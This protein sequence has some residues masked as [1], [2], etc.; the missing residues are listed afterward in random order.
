M[1]KAYKITSVLCLL[2]AVLAVVVG[3]SALTA[4]RRSFFMGYALFG[5]IRS[6]GVMG[7]IGNVFIIVFTVACYG[8]TGL[9]AL[10]DN[11]KSALIWGALSCV[12]AVVSLIASFFA[13]STTFGDFVVTAIPI[14]HTLFVVKSAD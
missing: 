9:N 2:M 6:G 7:F 13:K 3:I 11:K 14:A 4:G 10:V 1:K 12:L 8:L 5:L